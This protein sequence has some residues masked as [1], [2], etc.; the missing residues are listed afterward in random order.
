MLDVQNYILYNYIVL[1]M[2]FVFLHDLICSEIRDGFLM[3][4]PKCN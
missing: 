3:N 1:Y 4:Y 2:F